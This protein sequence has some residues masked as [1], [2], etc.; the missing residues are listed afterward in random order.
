M[1][2]FN[3]AI[4]W[5]KEGKKVRRPSWEENNYWILGIDEKISFKDGTTT[6]IH[7][8]QIEAKDW[9]IYEEMKITGSLAIGNNEKC[10]FCDEILDDR[11]KGK[12]ILKHIEKYHKEELIKTL[13]PK[14]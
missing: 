3:Q 1:S 11:I 7:V 4:K 12:E 6:H 13:F 2:N 8:N 14:K 5:L 9:E 10:P